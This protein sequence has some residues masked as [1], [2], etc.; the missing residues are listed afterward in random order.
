MPSYTYFR[1][2]LTET[3]RYTSLKHGFGVRQPWNEIWQPHAWRWLWAS[4]IVIF[5]RLSLFF[6][7]N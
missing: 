4:Y 5:F 6:L 1:A 3:I 7:K 2:K